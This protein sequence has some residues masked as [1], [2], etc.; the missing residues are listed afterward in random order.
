L[1]EPYPEHFFIAASGI[2]FGL[3]YARWQVRRRMARSRRIGRSAE[4]SAVKL[5]RR[6]GYRIVE[7]QPT[8]RVE[9]QVDDRI[10]SFLVRGDLLVRHRRR[11]YLAE[12]K[13]GAGSGTIAHRA[14]RRQLLEYATLFP[15]DGVL[16]VYVPARRIQ[17]VRFPALHQ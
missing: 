5:L 7:R 10:E 15:V 12:I 6:A 13:G 2:F 8:A 9:V 3:A 14:T 16:L 4:R 17:R 11:L 1:P